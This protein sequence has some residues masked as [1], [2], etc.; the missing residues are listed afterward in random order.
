ME[1]SEADKII[2]EFMKATFDFKNETVS[3]LDINREDMGSTEKSIVYHEYFSKSL[4]AL[5]PVWEKLN[6]E[7]RFQRENLDGTGDWIAVEKN[8]FRMQSGGGNTWTQSS[9]IQQAA[10]IATSKAILEL[11]GGS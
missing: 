9:S 6:T 3:F 10:A 4:D 1:P 5:V 8:D 11:K 7:I 2:A